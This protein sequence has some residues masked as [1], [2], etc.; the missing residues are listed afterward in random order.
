VEKGRNENQQQQQQQTQERQVRMTATTTN[1]FIHFCPLHYNTLLASPCR[2]NNLN[3]N[4]RNNFFPE[5]PFK[6]LFVFIATYKF[7][8]SGLKQNDCSIQDL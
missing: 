5:L 3:D 2:L 7:L 1:A 8:K 4:K 6:R